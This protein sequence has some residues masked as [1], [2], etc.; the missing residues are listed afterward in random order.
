MQSE[1]KDLQEDVFG[2]TDKRYLKGDTGV[3]D[4]YDHGGGEN[5]LL[6]QD[7]LSQHYVNETFA[8]IKQGKINLHRSKRMTWIEDYEDLSILEYYKNRRRPDYD[9]EEGITPDDNGKRRRYNKNRRRHNNSKSSRKTPYFDNNC[10][11]CGTMTIGGRHMR[12]GSLSRVINGRIVQPMYK[13]PWVVSFNVPGIGIYCGGAIISANFVLTA[14]HCLVHHER[15]ETPR[16][17]KE[18][19]PPQYCYFKPNEATIGLLSWRHSD[20]LRIVRIAQI[21]PHEQFD[22]EKILNDIGLIRLAAPIQCN[23]LS[24]P[25]CLPTRDLKNLGGMLV[26]AGWGYNT[27]EGRMGPDVLREGLMQQVK[28]TVCKRL[29]K[30]FFNDVKDIICTVGAKSMQSACH[31][32]SGSSTFGEFGHKVYTLGITSRHSKEN[33]ESDMPVTYSKVFRYIKWIKSYVKDLPQN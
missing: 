33:C 28:P 2:V 13:Y 14:S 27:E 31:G 8:S 22:N 30:P 7:G 29:S 5:D 15:G 17:A 1:E 26:V 10:Q 6:H 21:I 23:Q 3:S 19:P 24:S 32:D 12:K 20:K 25:I 4:G 18:N 11:I 16:C 9:N